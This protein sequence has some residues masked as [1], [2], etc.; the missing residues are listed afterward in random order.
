[1]FSLRPRKGRSLAH[2]FSPLACRCFPMQRIFFLLL[3]L[4]EVIALFIR[5]RKGKPEESKTVRQWALLGRIPINALKPSYIW[6]TQ[7][8]GPVTVYYHE[9]NTREMTEEEKADF[10]ADQKGYGQRYLQLMIQERSRLKRECGGT[11]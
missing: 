5:R 7:T 10:L 9:D 1:T 11:E 2:P 8:D 3:F 4:L 6:E